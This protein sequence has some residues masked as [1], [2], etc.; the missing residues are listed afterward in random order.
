M[1]EHAVI[2]A[3]T[4]RGRRLMLAEW[5]R[6][7]KRALDTEAETMGDVVTPEHLR[8]H[9]NFTRLCKWLDANGGDSGEI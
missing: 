3:R 1:P 2:E 7:E 9:E 8:R 6:E 4:I 5:L